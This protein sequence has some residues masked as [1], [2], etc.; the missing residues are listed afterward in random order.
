[1]H[2]RGA[3]RYF[4]PISKKMTGP[5]GRVYYD[6]KKKMYYSCDLGPMRGGKLRQARLSFGSPRVTRDNQRDTI[7]RPANFPTCS[8]GQPTV[9]DRAGINLD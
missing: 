5:D 3:K 8:E 7:S 2:G 6:V 4:R 9:A 1:M